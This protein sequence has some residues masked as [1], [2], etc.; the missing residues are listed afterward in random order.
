MEFSSSACPTMK[1]S[2]EQVPLLNLVDLH[3][4][5]ELM[6]FKNRFMGGTPLVSVYISL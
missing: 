1:L 3:T 6:T 2:L 5:L 4:E